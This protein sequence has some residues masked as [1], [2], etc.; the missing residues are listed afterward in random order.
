MKDKQHK[1][2]SEIYQRTIRLTGGDFKGELVS[3]NEAM[4]LA[5]EMNLDLVLFGVQENIGICKI[6]NYEKFLYELGKKE[7]E[8]PKVLELKEIKIGPNISEND[9]KYRINHLIE[10]LSKGHKVKISMQ[11]K[12]REMSYITNGETLMLQMI[13]AVK[14]YGSAEAM[15]K[16][17]NKKMFVTIKPINKSGK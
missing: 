3:L 8:K 17:E 14:D 13:L 15:P 11:F 4:A 5:D 12:G 9:L 7:K 1:I 6:I 2:N 10:F 16:L